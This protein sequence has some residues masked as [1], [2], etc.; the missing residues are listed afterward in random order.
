ME[1]KIKT[2]RRLLLNGADC[3][4]E[5]TSDFY[6]IEAYIYEHTHEHLGLNTIK[7][8]FGYG[9][10]LT[11]PRNA[12]LDIISRAL[13]YR[14]FDDYAEHHNST[15]NGS[16]IVLSPAVKSRDLNSGDKVRLCWHEGRDVTVEY[17]GNDTYRV[18]SSIASK[19]KPGD[20]FQAPFFAI[21]HTCMISNLVHGD[22]CFPLYEMGKQG[23]L[24]RA[25]V[26]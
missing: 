24:T 14:N 4:A 6:R 16:D 17:L 9:G 10:E 22:S 21:G 3:R 25:E 8:F 23:G 15:D 19:L 7:R 18:L 2:M 1:E 5:R 11:T 26:V 20:T 12:T 13:G